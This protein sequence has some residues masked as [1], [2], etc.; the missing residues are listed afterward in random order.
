MS[1]KFVVVVH[2]Q[3]SGRANAGFAG[4]VYLGGVHGLQHALL[5]T[6]LM[7]LETEA[8]DVAKVLARSFLVTVL[9][10]EIEVEAGD[11]LLELG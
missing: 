1:P 3:E 4:V 8:E 9:L 2:V 10:L 5:S 7:L 11:L 6:V